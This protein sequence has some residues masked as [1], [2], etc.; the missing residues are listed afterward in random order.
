MRLPSFVVL[1]GQ[2][3]VENQHP[4]LRLGVSASVPA[5]T[6]RRKEDRKMKTSQHEGDETNPVESKSPSG[7][8]RAVVKLAASDLTATQ[9]EIA[10]V[11]RFLA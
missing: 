3:R 8:T 11:A 5:K 9:A 7:D 6:R 1:V 2:D 10:T 4:S